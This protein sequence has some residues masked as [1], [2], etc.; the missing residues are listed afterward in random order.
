MK[1]IFS[2]GAGKSCV[3]ESVCVCGGGSGRV[4]GFEGGGVV[5][6]KKIKEYRLREGR[7]PHKTQ[8]NEAKALKKNWRG[9]D[10]LYP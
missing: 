4:C 2:R 1:G 10:P 5:R 6:T 7:N 9:K 8:R 3:F